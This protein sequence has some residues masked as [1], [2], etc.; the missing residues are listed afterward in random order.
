MKRKMRSF[1]DN[2]ISFL[3]QCEMLQQYVESLSILPPQGEEARNA[4][5]EEINDLC[6]K[7][8]KKLN[9]LNKILVKY[10]REAKNERL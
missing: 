1:A 6:G 3:E 8:H 10:I 9:K 2:F 5:S 7:L 4:I